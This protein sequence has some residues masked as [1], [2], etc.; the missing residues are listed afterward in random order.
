MIPLVE[1]GCPARCRPPIRRP[2]IRPQRPVYR[3]A[4]GPREGVRCRPGWVAFTR[5]VSDPELI[6][7]GGSALTWA[8]S[9]C[10]G[11]NRGRLSR[12]NRECRTESRKTR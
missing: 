5:K 11:R 4:V 1:R 10:S 9:S 3:R 2:S 12:T 8:L 6:E 7:T